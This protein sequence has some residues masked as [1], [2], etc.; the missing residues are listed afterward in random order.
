MI[1]EKPYLELALG[2]IQRQH[3]DE[4]RTVL[5]R[6]RD[7]ATAQKWLLWLDQY[8][9]VPAWK[10]GGDVTY[11]TD[12]GQHTA[13][14]P[15][16]APQPSVTMTDGVAVA[17]IES[18]EA[19]L[20]RLSSPSKSQLIT[21]QIARINAA[22]ADVETEYRHNGLMFLT[23]IITLPALGVGAVLIGYSIYNVAA[24]RRQMHKLYRRRRAL[25]LDLEG[26]YTTTA[27]GFNTRPTNSTLAV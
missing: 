12:E 11:P 21:Q 22:I 25:L 3:Y 20:K 8:A 24:K 27:Y 19:V 5:E 15:V 2:L 16:T 23:G 17:E 4:A 10:Q 14:V 18:P 26:R 1:A 6:V 7:H 9:P 13:V